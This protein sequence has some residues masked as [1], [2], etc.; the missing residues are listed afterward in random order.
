MY[1]MTDAVIAYVDA[2]AV[3]FLITGVTI[4][5]Y[6]LDDVFVDVVFWSMRLFGLEAN[7]HP[8]IPEE[9]LRSMP[10]RPIAVM[11]P[12]WHEHDVIYAMLK[13]NV[14]HT[15]Y[16]VFFV[17]AYPNDLAT[18]K[19]VL[20]AAADY[21]YN[22]KLVVGPRNGPTTKADC[23]NG[24]LRHIAEY[25]KG[26]GVEFVGCALH[27]SEDVVHPLEFALFNAL[28]DETDFIQLPVFSFSRSLTHMVAGSYMDEFAEFHNKDLV[29]RERLTG[30]IPCAGVA[31]CFSRR[32]IKALSED[33]AEEVFDPAALTED[34]DVAFRIK[35]LG[36]RSA[37]IRNDASFTLDIPEGSATLTRIEQRLAIATRE[38]FPDDFRAAYR[39]RARWILGIGFQGANNLGWGDNLLERIFFLRDRKGIASGLIAIT[40]YFLTFNAVLI[41]ILTTVS[42]DWR[43][44]AYVLLHPVLQTVFLINV[45]LLANRLLQRTIFTTHVYGIAQGLMA[46]P[47][48][49]FSNCLNF[50]AALRALYIFYWRHRIEKQPLSWDKTQH[51]IPKGATRALEQ[52]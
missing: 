34:Y 28:L 45:V 15:P 17:G 20:R 42:D 21:P 6:S 48:V 30:F 24:V 4:I 44:A 43:I 26:H 1:D 27:D 52:A 11:V 16:V 41:A 14:I 18:Q 40:G 7:R 33:R 39:Q 37:F 47:R 9:R 36:L 22:V 3:L 13:A 35:K 46:A 31:A 49:V 23:L 25:E 51:T 12:A 50:C 38:Y 19:E 2:V 8:A 32:A 29:V 5:V 10:M